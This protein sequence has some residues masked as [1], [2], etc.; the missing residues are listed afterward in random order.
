VCMLMQCCT[1]Q[2]SVAAEG[3]RARAL[4]CAVQQLWWWFGGG[5]GRARPPPVLQSATCTPAVS[6]SA[7]AVV[8]PHSRSFSRGEEAFALL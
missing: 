3:G 1:M 6:G 4:A 2:L 8:L 7:C 5:G